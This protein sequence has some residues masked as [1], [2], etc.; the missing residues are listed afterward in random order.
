MMTSWRVEEAMG[1]NV[2]AR[3]P[4]RIEIFDEMQCKSAK[5]FGALV[6][7]SSLK[8]MQHTLEGRR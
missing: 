1:S 7:Y 5:L 4:A 6:H 8:M 3:R 2:A